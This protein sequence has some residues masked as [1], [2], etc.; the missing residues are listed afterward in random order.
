MLNFVTCEDIVQ[1]PTFGHQPVVMGGLYSEITNEF[2]PAMTLWSTE[3]IQ[4][5]ITVIHHPYQDMFW[6]SEESMDEKMEKFKIEVG[7]SLGVSLKSAAI[8]AEGSFK[9]LTEKKV[10]LKRKNIK[11]NQTK[12]KGTNPF[13]SSSP[14]QILKDPHVHSSQKQ[15]PPGHGSD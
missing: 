14:S 12:P 10:N 13:C 11:P 7:G 9:Y 6:T 3:D 1:I 15:A 5:S 2:L 8:K 4:N